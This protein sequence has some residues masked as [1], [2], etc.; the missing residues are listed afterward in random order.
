[1]SAQQYIPVLPESAP[2]TPWQRAYLNGFFA[3]LFSRTPMA[4]AAATPPPTAP[5]PLR[6]L[7]ILFGSQ[8]GNA[9]KLAKQIAKQAGQCGFAPT[10]YEMVKY[11]LAQLASEWRVLIVTSTFGDGDPPDNAK[12]FWEFLSSDAAPRLPELRFSVCALGDSSYAKFCGFGKDVDARLEKLGATRAH[13]RADCDVEFEAAFANWLSE[14]LSALSGVGSPLTPALSPSEG[15]RENRSQA[16]GDTNEITNSGGRTLLSP[17][18]LG[19][20]EGQGEGET[21]VT[22]SRANPFLARL[23]TNRKLNAPGSG[24]DVRHFEI[25]LSGSGL[26]YE[27]GDALGV[28]PQNDP[29]LVSELL[30]ALGATG[31]EAVP[32]QAGGH[33]A[34][35][36]ALTSHFEITRIPKPLLEMFAARAGDETLSRVAAPTANGE[37]TNFLWGRQI[38]DLLLAHPNVKLSPAE[39]VILL[40]KLQ[41]RLYSISSSP[42]AHPGEVHLTVSA[43]R[44]ESLGHARAGAC[45]TFLADRVGPDMSVPVFVHQNRSFRPPAPD[46]PLIMVGPGTGI[47]PFRA[48]LEERRAIGANGKNWL[49][50]GDQK[51][52]T[53]FLYRGEIEGF[54]KSGALT[55]LDVAWSRDQEEKIYVQ[56]RLLEHAKEVFDWLERG[57]AF[58]VCGDASRMAKDVDAALHQVI[59]IAAGKSA[60]QAADCVKALSASKRYQRDVY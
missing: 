34:L 46:T 13:P 58:Y 38:I 33:I 43:L 8:T 4:G 25:S 60:Q 30:A 1:M 15:E 11:P 42:K 55:R 41:P 5:H 23:L 32:I 27:V 2:F 47:A 37:L 36:E 19:G 57:G 29:A 6:P 48:F 14:A 45:S 21:R 20:G 51:S 3:G 9:E 31:D 17:L 26:N 53:D 22:Y 18:P 52:S 39:F 50:F 7:S 56:H 12:A 16:A 28:V 24:K 54:Q 10:I 40:R 59:Q 35:R 49:F 44:Y